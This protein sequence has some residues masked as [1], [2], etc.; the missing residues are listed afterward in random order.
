[1][2]AEGW[3]WNLAIGLFGCAVMVA[4]LQAARPG[5][6]ALVTGLVLSTTDLAIG[7]L[8]F[9][10]GGR[11]LVGLQAVLWLA[12]L[13]YATV[14][15]L[16]TVFERQEVEV[17]TLLAALCVYLILGLIWVY[18]YALIGL[19]APA[20]FR[21]PGEVPV[22]WWD[23]ASRRTEF[24]RML[25]LSY[26][27]LTTIGVGDL[28]P[29]SGLACIVANLEAISGQ[30]YLAVVIA[31]LVGMHVGQAPPSPPEAPGAGPSAS[32]DGPG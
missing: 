5:R 15:I 20:S 9:H 19:A 30:V 32:A 25:I 14:E 6:R 29:A 17:E 28:A 10:Q 12:T 22:A 8:I 26:S 1:L 4:G 24:M 13:V 21:L 27:T 23:D 7:R 3:V 16:G 18:L 31:R 2:I 11:W